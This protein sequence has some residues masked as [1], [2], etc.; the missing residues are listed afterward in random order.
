[1]LKINNLNF[2]YQKNI[3]VLKDISFTIDKPQ[4]VVLL[5]QNGS[6]KTT[7]LKSI[8]GLVKASG[9][10]YLNEINFNTLKPNERA[11]YISYL[12]QQSIVEKL[13][14][15][16][17]LILG[18][19]PYFNIIPS[20]EDME[21]VD[22]KANELKINHLLNKDIDELSGGELQLVLTA[23]VLIQDTPIIVFDEPT[24]SLDI[25]NEILLLD[26]AKKM[27]EEH[28]KIIIAAIHDLTTAIN[29]GDYF[30]L[31]KDGK[32]LEQGDISIITSENLSKIFDINLKITEIEN[33]KIVIVEE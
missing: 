22:K 31:I 18:R 12:P 2:Q 5:G 1:M 16:D 24:S 25:K 32:I 28:Q 14:V 11:K 30:I 4:M 27:V 33:R 15:K 19:L 13:S 8:L 17:T 29:Y 7:L 6:G 21:I 10:I 26:I 9:E 23:K 20:R 3:Q